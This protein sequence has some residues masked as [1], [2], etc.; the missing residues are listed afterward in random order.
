MLTTLNTIVC[1]VF[2]IPRTRHSDIFIV[3]KLQLLAELTL[4]VVPL[5][6]AVGTLDPIF[7]IKQVFRPTIILRIYLATMVTEAVFVVEGETARTKSK[8]VLESH[9]VL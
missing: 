1:E 9:V 2:I 8:F 3:G 6:V 4:S 7:A 5:L